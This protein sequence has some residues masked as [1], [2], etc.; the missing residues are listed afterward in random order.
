MYEMQRRDD[1]GLLDYTHHAPET[2]SGSLAH[3]GTLP[4]GNNSEG[5]PCSKPEDA[6][7]PM[8]PR[9]ESENY[10][11]V[12]HE[13]YPEVKID[14]NTLPEV[15][16]DDGPQLAENE[17][18]KAGSAK[19]RWLRKRWLWTFTI[20]LVIIIVVAI[21]GGMVGSGAAS[22]SD[23]NAVNVL[24]TTALASVSYKQA[25]ATTQYRVYFQAES[26]AL[27]QSVWSSETK[28]WRTSPLRRPDAANFTNEP[29]VRLGT[30]L[31]AHIYGSVETVSHHICSA[32]M[33]I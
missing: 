25:D 14:Q 3:R 2:A 33:C 6:K 16:G 26:G 22:R 4:R 18:R 1:H 15:V 12:Y 29:E 13:T 31:T 5:H 27:Y 9:I 32:R 28:S 10:P 19:N 11:E 21:V 24:E 7:L 17:A 8:V 23:R 30:P 20:L